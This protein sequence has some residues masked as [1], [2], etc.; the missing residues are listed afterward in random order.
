MNQERKLRLVEALAA[1]KA[2]GNDP[3]AE[4]VR[5]ALEQNESSQSSSEAA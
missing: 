4:A 1:S 5:I 2:K 3:L